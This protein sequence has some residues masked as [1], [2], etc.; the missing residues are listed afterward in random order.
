MKILHFGKYYPTYFG[1]VEKVN[2]DL[3][4][5]INKKMIVKLTNCVLPIRWIIKIY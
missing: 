4:E 2:Y 5:E 3:V 1:G